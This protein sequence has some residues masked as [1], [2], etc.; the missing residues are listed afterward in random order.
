MRTPRL[1]ALA[2][3]LVAACGSAEDPAP[4]PPVLLLA[5]DGLEW[6][7]LLPMVQRG[8][9]PTLRGLMER[10][11]FGRLRTLNPTV[12]PVIW[13]TIATGKPPA[14]HGIHGFVYADEGEQQLYTSA[15]R[16]VKAFW[17][18]LSDQGLDSSVFG[19][20]ITWPAEHVRGLMVAQANT[21]PR[22]G[23][24]EGGRGKKGGLFED[25]PG[26]VFP[27]A[28]EPRV[29]AILDEVEA[30]LDGVMAREYGFPEVELP[31]PEARLV[32]G[33]R[34]TL[35]ADETYLRL[36]AD[37]LARREPSAVTAVYI[38][39]TDVIAHRFWRYAFPEEFT[40]PVAP[41]RLELLGGLLEAA[42]RRADQALG[43]LLRLLPEEATVLVVSDHGM[44]AVQ[45]AGRFPPDNALWGLISAGHFDEPP[46]VLIAAGAGIRAPAAPPDL[47][48]LELEDLRDVGSVTDF[49][50]TLL[51][52]V[53]VPVGQDMA[54][55]VRQDWIDPAWL[56][57]HPVRFVETH[58]TPEWKEQRKRLQMRAEDHAE[59]LDQLRNLGYIG[60][61]D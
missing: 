27:P 3:L 39:A 57:S 23:V 50:P 22:N 7:V 55:E 42:Y 58:E 45:T 4:R 48:A 40:H 14:E 25:A 17:N 41:E 54:G 24:T 35:R 26:Q 61:D 37:T 46:G 16:E 30:G 34:W 20:W 51:A 38:G 49:T 18:I 47:D 43:E 21:P 53:D 13:T 11:V 8:E 31:Q 44:H 9:M 6:S 19:W 32:K 15:D 59:R 29:L 33:T 28:E 12:S 56:E 1:I 2:S 36:A 52:L 5:V 10:G 60:G